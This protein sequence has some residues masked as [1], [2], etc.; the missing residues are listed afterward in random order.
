MN[1][2]FNLFARSDVLQATEETV[3]MPCNSNVSRL[4]RMGCSND[5]SHAAVQ[6]KIVSAFKDRHLQMNLWNVQYSQ[7]SAESM[8]QLALYA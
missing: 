1:S 7:R 6:S 5:A 3:P 8:T 2:Q 4:A